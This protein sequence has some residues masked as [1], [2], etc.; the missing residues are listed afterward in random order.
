MDILPMHDFITSCIIIQK[1]LNG[2]FREFMQIFQMLTHIIQTKKKKITFFNITTDLIGKV[3]KHWEA[4]KFAVLDTRFLKLE[5]SNLSLATNTV[6][7]F[8]WSDRPTLFI[9]EKMSTKYPSLNSYNLFTSHSFKS[10]WC[11]MKKAV[12]SACNSRN[13]YF[14]S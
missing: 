7:C 2:N 1:I 13:K 3:F 5:S 14:S 4:V 11:S 12:S 8:P 9:F 10:K 6:S